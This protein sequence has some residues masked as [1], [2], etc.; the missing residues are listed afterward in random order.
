MSEEIAN[1]KDSFI[2]CLFTNLLSINCIMKKYIFLFIVTVASVIS[3]TNSGLLETPDTYAECITFEPYLGNAPETKAAENSDLAFLKTGLAETPYSGG[4]E[5]F[6][7]EHKNDGSAPDSF[8]SSFMDEFVYWE[9]SANSSDES[10]WTSANLYYWPEDQ[11]LA[12]V[13]VGANAI[14]G[15]CLSRTTDMVNYAFEVKSKPSQQ[16]DLIVAPYQTSWNANKNGGVVNLK[17]E[18]LLS[19]IGFKIQS[20]ASNEGV[21]IAIRSIKLR[22]IFPTFGDLNLAD[23][24]P[25]VV[26]RDSETDQFTYE[27]SLFDDSSYSFTVASNECFGTAAEIYA[28]TRLDNE[29]SEWKPIYSVNPEAEDKNAEEQAIANAIA[30]AKNR[31]YMMLMPCDQLSDANAH[32]EVVYQLTEADTRTAVVPLGNIKFSANT[33]YEFI[34]TVSTATI[35]FDATLEKDEWDRAQNSNGENLPSEIIPLFPEK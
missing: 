4:F 13:A 21:D 8:V 33:T 1:I 16:V 17:F 24:Q 34:L 3:C 2:S 32:L 29:T 25:V 10:G 9:E 6:A 27:Y 18:H 11:D 15:N 20:T 31:R 35:A 12:F 23:E 5:V 19:R 22:G 7:F 30:T 28:N 14:K 26:A